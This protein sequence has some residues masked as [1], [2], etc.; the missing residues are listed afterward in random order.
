[1]KESIRS[2]NARAAWRGAIATAVVAIAL[3]VCSCAE[4]YDMTGVLKGKTLVYSSGPSTKDTYV[5]A[6]DGKSGTY[7][8]ERYTY[9]YPDAASEGDYTK[10]AWVRTGGSKG[11]FTY[12]PKT[13]EIVFTF[14]HQYSKIPGAT[15]SYAADYKEYALL[16][17]EKAWDPET[18]AVTSTRRRRLLFNQDSIAYAY[19][20][21]GTDQWVFSESSS[22]I[23]TRNGIIYSYSDSNTERLTVSRS[24]I[25]TSGAFDSESKTDASITEARHKRYD[26]TYSVYAAYRLGDTKVGEAFADIWKK[27]GVVTFRCNQASYVH[28]EWEGATEP[29]APSVS[30]ATGKGESGSEGSDPLNYYL[31]DMNAYQKTINLQHFGDY[32]AYFSGSASRGL[33]L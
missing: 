28:K 25:A 16:D 24:A 19:F 17:Y 21:S 9:K 22:Y 29:A 8:G 31:I 1:M 27:D 11:T 26:T 30:A 32:I 13:L 3:I 4:P 12:D 14:T 18:T 10:K 2:W 33:D 23:Y 5:F 15:T 20:P 6:A 7:A